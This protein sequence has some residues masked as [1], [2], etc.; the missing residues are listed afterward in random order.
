MRII[1]ATV[2][3]R[4]SPPPAIR[5][6]AFAAV[7]VEARSRFAAVLH[8][9]GVLKHIDNQ[10]KAV[11]LRMPADP[12]NVVIDGGLG[13]LQVE[14]DFLGAATP[15]DLLQNGSVLGLEFDPSHNLAQIG[16]K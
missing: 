15:T 8:G 2:L 5:F 14:G 11:D 3:R 6:V 4:P 10:L 7:K 13:N 12:S 9:R 1:E 16:L